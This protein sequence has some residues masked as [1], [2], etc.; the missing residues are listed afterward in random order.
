[1]P[2]GHGRIREIGFSASWPLSELSTVE[3]GLLVLK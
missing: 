1:M 3:M 2:S